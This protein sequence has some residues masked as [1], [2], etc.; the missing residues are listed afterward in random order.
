MALSEQA[1]LGKDYPFIVVAT[2]N[3][4]EI[5]SRASSSK[6]HASLA[7]QL[8]I[9]SQAWS[10]RMPKAHEA[11]KTTSRVH[12]RCDLIPSA[13]RYIIF[14]SID[15]ATAGDSSAKAQLTSGPK[16]NFESVFL[17]VLTKQNFHRLLYSRTFA[18]MRFL[19]SSSSRREMCRASARL[20][21]AKLYSAQ[22]VRQQRHRERSLMT[23][24][25][26][27]S[28]VNLFT[29]STNDCLKLYFYIFS[30][31]LFRFCEIFDL[32]RQPFLCPIYRGP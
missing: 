4:F 19:T 26:S 23:L 25:N 2:V 21:G 5:H 22:I 30:W 10:R 8:A 17:S 7:Y 18:T 29:F 3:E 11:L 1:R 27:S 24:I 32:E 12:P 13:S 6:D 28:L 20:N 14:E 15:E 16:N 9:Q 31:R